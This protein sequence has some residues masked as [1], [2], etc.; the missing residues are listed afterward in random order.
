MPSRDPSS[1]PV[2][3]L[4]LRAQ[5]GEGWTYFPPER[6]LKSVLKALGRRWGFDCLECREVVTP[7]EATAPAFETDGK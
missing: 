5:T 2:Y 4:R 1:P 3:L 6:R 7:T